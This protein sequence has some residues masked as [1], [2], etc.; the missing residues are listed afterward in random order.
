M[1]EPADIENKLILAV[2]CGSSSIKFKLYTASSLRSIFSGSAS[3]VEQKGLK[4]VI[5]YTVLHNE[6]GHE[7]EEKHQEEEDEHMPYELVFERIITLLEESQLKHFAG[8]DHERP[9]DL[10]RLVAHRVVHGGTQSEPMVL[11]PGHEEG[12]DL[13]DKLAEFAPLHN[14]RS[15]I[16]VKSCLE[17][18]SAAHQV[19][20]YDTLFHHTIPA[21]VYTYPIAPP[22]EPSPVPLRRYGFH[23][24]SYSAI[25][26]SVSNYLGKKEEDTN[27]VVAHLGSGASMCLIRSGKSE[28]T[29]MGLSPLEGLPGGTRTGCVDPVLIFHHTPSSVEIV[30]Y[31]GTDITKAEL[32]LNTDGGL[33]ALAGTSDFG[34]I[35]SHLPQGFDPFSLDISPDDKYAFTYAL[36]LDRVC[37]F[38]GSYLNKLKGHPTLPTHL[39][40][41]VFSGGIGEH[42]TRLRA[43][44]AKYLHWLGA[45]LDS[46]AN[47]LDSDDVVIKIST[48]SSKIP[49]FICKTDEEQQ[50]ARMAH[51]YLF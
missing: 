23:G 29:T 14:H 31:K 39:D 38:L 10:I 32:V 4:P 27:L 37:N 43:D 21:K 15:I 16:V 24:L 8:E 22:K 6:H 20:C 33:Q 46:Q 18:L 34:Q 13:L 50:C 35:I 17:H 9:R 41:I 49:M 48:E 36:F 12:I 3:N 30:S 5:K 1:P 11:W 2:N 19:L 25:L 42:A 26:R 47:G 45:E 40:G 28:D 51:P 44:I 7:E